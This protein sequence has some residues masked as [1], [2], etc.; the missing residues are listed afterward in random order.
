MIII[1]SRRGVLAG[2]GL[3]SLAAANSSLAAGPSEDLR[4][5]GLMTENVTGPVGV[6]LADMRLSWRLET[7]KRGTMQ[8]AYQI[9]VASSAGNLKAG[10]FD[11]WDSGRIAGDQSFDIAYRGKPLASRQRAHCQVKVCDNHKRVATSAPAFWDMGL[12]S[13][14]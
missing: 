8:S 3:A 14:S 2:A 7:A 5:L 12:L 6:Q 13:R 4:V 1:P 10:K 9:Q 11:L